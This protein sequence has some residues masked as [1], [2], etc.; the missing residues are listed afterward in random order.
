MT[1]E[2]VPPGTWP[3]GPELAGDALVAAFNARLRQVAE[4][5]VILRGRGR[6]HRDLTR[7][8]MASGGSGHDEVVRK[9]EAARAA[10][11]RYRETRNRPEP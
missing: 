11:R 8:T 9:I 6:L 5:A 2:I 10:V 7:A 1:V 4:S 3:V